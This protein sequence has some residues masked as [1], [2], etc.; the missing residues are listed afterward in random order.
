MGLGLEVSNEPGFP[1]VVYVPTMVS[2]DGHLRLEMMV[3]NDGR[4]ALFVYSAIDRLHQ[5]YQPGATWVLLT[6]D[7]LQLAYNAEPFDLLF[8]DKRPRANDS[9]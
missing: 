8:L 7:D 6:V 3:A 5:F 2:P 9:L 4:T 1:P